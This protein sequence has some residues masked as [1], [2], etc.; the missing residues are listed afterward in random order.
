MKHIGVGSSF[1][2]NTQYTTTHNADKLYMQESP[3]THHKS[4]KS[5][6]YQQKPALGK[7][8]PVHLHGHVKE[9]SD[10]QDKAGHGGFSMAIGGFHI[11]A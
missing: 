5:T 9:N 4:L 3:A 1:M 11:G 8:E 10:Y 7:L 2:H 6:I